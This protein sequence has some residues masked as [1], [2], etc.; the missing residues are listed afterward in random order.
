MEYKEKLRYFFEGLEME[1]IDSLMEKSPIELKFIGSVMA[2]RIKDI[3]MLKFFNGCIGAEE[4][5]A[6]FVIWSTFRDEDDLLRIE[7]FETIKEAEIR[8][9]Q[10]LLQFKNENTFDIKK[11]II[12]KEVEIKEIVTIELIV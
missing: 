5:N 10:L 3:E 4:K 11:V 7:K 12:G 8:I 1:N 6:V 2:S 9:K